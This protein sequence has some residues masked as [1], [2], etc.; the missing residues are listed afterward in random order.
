M[1]QTRPLFCLFSFF[2][3]TNFT[4]K[5]QTSAGFK[6]GSLEYKTCTLTTRPLPCFPI[7][8]VGKQL[9]M[10]LANQPTLGHFRYRYSVDIQVRPRYLHA[11]DVRQ[12]MQVRGHLFQHKFHPHHNHFS[13][14][15]LTSWDQ[16]YCK[17]LFWQ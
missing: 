14:V 1:G 2:L 10:I 6:L 15:R 7:L 12:M 3:N 8:Q 4:E 16:Y 13:A 11:S 9:K 5:L 17:A